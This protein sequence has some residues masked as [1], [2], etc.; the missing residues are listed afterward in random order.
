[1]MK[2]AHQLIPQKCLF[3]T[4]EEHYIIWF[5]FHHSY[6][7]FFFF[8]IE[9]KEMST[10]ILRTHHQD[11]NMRITD[12]RTQRH[13][14]NMQKIKNPNDYNVQGV[15]FYYSKDSAVVVDAHPLSFLPL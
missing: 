3:S 7:F 2:T 9:F 4:M 5:V 12:T 8:W 6:T 10:A 13:C 11:S 1:M 15:S 14:A